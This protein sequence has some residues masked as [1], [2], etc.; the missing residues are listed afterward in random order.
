MGLL[1]IDGQYIIFRIF[2][3]AQNDVSM[4]EIR[5]I[6]LDLDDTLWA[7]EPV[8]EAAEQRLYEWLSAHCPRVALAH[9][10][11]TMREIRVIVARD[12]EDIAHDL[13]EIRRRALEHLIVTEAAYPRSMVDDAMTEF[14]EH[15]NRVELFPD[16]MP[17]LCR[18]S[19]SLPL[20]SISNGNA[21]LKRV[22]L[23][24]LFVTH[25]SAREVGAAKPDP[26]P[27]LA[28][29]ERLNL[30][31]EQVLHIG[32]H[33]VQDILGAARVGM[34]TVWIN[35]R[36]ARWEEDFSADYEVSSLDQVL[37]LLAAHGFGDR[38]E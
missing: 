4:D 15:R 32:D 31:P 25:V 18:V 10:V 9:D 26:R 27:F 23:N 29:C 38:N 22:G 21:D 20:L 28:A 34:R 37:D 33:P 35:R 7:I 11:H 14:L 8:I 24:D 19:E 12:N 13:T 3:S 30:A 36:E 17:F 16:V 2:E 6:T 1:M 5:A